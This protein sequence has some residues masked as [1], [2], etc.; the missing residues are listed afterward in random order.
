MNWTGFVDSGTF[1]FGEPTITK[2]RPPYTPDGSASIEASA[3]RSCG[4]SRVPIQILD[5][6]RHTTGGTSLPKSNVVTTT[7]HQRIH[8][9]MTLGCDHPPRHSAE[10]GFTQLD[11]SCK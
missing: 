11:D 1:A 5:R 4:S 7:R 8:H 2:T 3:P 6:D 10:R 9:R